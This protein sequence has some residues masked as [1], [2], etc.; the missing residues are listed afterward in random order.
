MLKRLIYPVTSRIEKRLA[1]YN[2]SVSPPRVI[3]PEVSSIDEIKTQTLGFM[4][5]MRIYR[6]GRFNGY[7][8]AASTKKPVLYA[9]LA[10]LLTRH[11][12]GEHGNKQYL[13]EIEYVR[14]FQSD[15]GLFRDPE[16]ECELADKEDW[17]GWRHLTLH[18]LMTLALYGVPA[19]KE[20][21]YIDQF[22]DE[23][24]FRDYLGSRDWG[25]R[26][27]WTSNELQN[28]G[29]MLQYSR[30]YQNSKTAGMLMEILYEEMDARQDAKTGIY[31]DRFSTPMELS[32]GVQAGYHFW[33]LYLYD[34]RPVKH[35]ERIID[36]ALKTQNLLGGFGVQLYSS[37]CEDIDSIDPLIRFTRTTDYRAKE[38]QVSLQRALSAVLH[39]LNADGGWAFR[40]RE[41]MT[42][43][44]PQ[45]H[46][47]ADESNMLH[48]WFR[49]L[50]LAYCLTGLDDVPEAL[51][52]KWNFVR[53]PGH[54]FM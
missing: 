8:H 49:T 42:M 28:L 30:D 50:G 1:I 51:R 27:A 17:W 11:L 34:R 38:I 20:I 18:A 47:D 14:G 29:V 7:R 31:G 16:I 21:L 40:R 33:L 45:M 24:R 13:E 12:Y 32:N 37:A 25:D 26:A 35:V 22:K 15:D 6:Q 23:K 41:E 5:G 9:T 36:S 43:V 54:Q 2:A 48:T 10:A 46:S 53:A 3:M 4:N 19:K 52:Y 44:H 39:N